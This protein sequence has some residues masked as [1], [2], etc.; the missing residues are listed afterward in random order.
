MFAKLTPAHIATAEQLTK[1]FPK[2]SKI[3]VHKQKP[4]NFESSTNARPPP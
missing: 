4:Y 2:T 3:T 1:Q